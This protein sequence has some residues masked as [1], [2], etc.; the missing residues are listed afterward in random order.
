MVGDGVGWAV[1]AGDGVGVGVGGGVGVGVG[2]GVRSGRA[3]ACGS[4]SM[5]ALRSAST[6]DPG[7]A[8][9]WASAWA[10]TADWW[11]RSPTPPRRA[12]CAR[13]GSGRGRSSR[14]RRDAA[15]SRRSRRIPP[16][17]TVTTAPSG[18]LTPSGFSSS[19]PSLSVTWTLT[20]LASASCV[21]DPGVPSA[22][23]TATAATATAAP[24]SA[25]QR[26]SAVVRLG[27]LVRRCGCDRRALGDREQP[28]L[29]AVRELG[30]RRRRGPAPGGLEVAAGIVGHDR[31]SA[32]RV[33]RSARVARWSTTAIVAFDVPMAAAASSGVRPE[34]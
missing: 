4:A 19:V 18:R 13:C 17:P 5:S 20:G 8:I 30:V 16:S 33:R 28:R 11:A 26:R 12:G 14:R 21:S 1:G 31:S 15:R 29:E 9:P 27:P 6:F 7:P 34:R 24:V 2:L 10:S 25:S 3:S 22:T 32:A 23:S